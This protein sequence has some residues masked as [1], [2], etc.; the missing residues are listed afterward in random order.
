MDLTDDD[1]KK[2]LSYELM[3]STNLFKVYSEESK[4]GYESTLKTSKVENCG[5]IWDR[6]VGEN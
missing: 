1:V 3:S 4:Q 2:Y 6:T 5:E